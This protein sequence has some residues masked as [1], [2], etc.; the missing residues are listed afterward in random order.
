MNMQNSRHLTQDGRNGTGPQ[1]HCGQGGAPVPGHERADRH[2]H[3]A[4][5]D[6]YDDGLVHGHFWAMSSTVR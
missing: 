1:G 5:Q 3:T 4:D 6:G 2:N